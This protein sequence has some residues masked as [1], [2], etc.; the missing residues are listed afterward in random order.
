[1]VIMEKWPVYIGLLVVLVIILIIIWKSSGPKGNGGYG[2]GDP[3]FSGA[4]WKW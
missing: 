2:S 4:G 3:G 1:M